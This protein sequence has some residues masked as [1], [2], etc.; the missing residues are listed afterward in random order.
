MQSHVS[1]GDFSRMTHL[2]VKTLRHYH[3]VGLVEP[4]QVDSATGYRYYSLAQ[5]PTAQVVR[6]LRELDMPI[7]DI[8]AVLVSVPDVRNQLIA[9]HLN[10]LEDE[11]ASTRQAVNALRDILLRPSDASAVIAHRTVAAVA[12][13]AIQEVVERDDLLVWWQG[14]LG[15]L[16]ATVDAQHLAQAGASG[17]LYASDIFQHDCG[18]ATVFIPVEGT[19]RRIGRVMPMTVPPAELAVMRH[20]GPLD[21]VDLIYGALGS[22]AARH[23]ISVDGPLREYYV[24]DA[25]NTPDP[26]RWQTDVGWPVFRADSGH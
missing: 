10:R 24:C 26:S 15:E 1:I 22:Y 5:I 6:R 2:S 7:P 25:W 11:L 9:N 8:K 4:D 14:A 3:D 23:E 19:V 13:I 12:A 18:H 16:H 21:D 17:G 20:F